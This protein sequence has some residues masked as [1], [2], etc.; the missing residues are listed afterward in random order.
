MTRLFMF[1]LL[2][3]AICGT[4]S[5]AWAQSVPLSSGLEF[6]LQSR[7]SSVT[8][9]DRDLIVPRS[10][11]HNFIRS[12]EAGRAPGGQMSLNTYAFYGFHPY[13]LSRF[14]LAMTGA[15][16]AA[17]V[18]LFIGA[19]GTTTGLFEED[20]AWYLVGAMTAIGAILGGTVGA[21]SPEK[22]LR[23]RWEP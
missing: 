22:R 5:P 9:D 16:A 4:S 15:G 20:S 21:N 11:F 12:A 3:S 1:V 17:T 23:Y 8:H 6:R 14:D 7:L 2:L 13:E 18:G 10:Y 19:V